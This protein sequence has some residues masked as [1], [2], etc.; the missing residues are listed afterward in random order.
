ALLI[1][2]GTCFAA[3]AKKQILILRYQ[4]PAEAL[5]NSTDCGIAE[6]EVA[7]AHKLL[8]KSLRKQGVDVQLGTFSR[9]EGEG[10]LWIN[11]QPLE[12]WLQGKDLC[13]VTAEQIVEAGMSA[14]EQ[15]RNANQATEVKPTA[16]ASRAAKSQASS[17]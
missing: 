15:Q 4:P 9:S 17:N 8:Q 12:I 16:S 3:G 5:V 2:A 10:K 11:N 7:K 13:R 14:V 1:A 6:A